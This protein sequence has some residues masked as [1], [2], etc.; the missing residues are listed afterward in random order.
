MLDITYGMYSMVHYVHLWLF[1]GSVVL[2]Q[3][4]A[5]TI[6]AISRRIER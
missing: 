1:G 4:C 6:I 3:A 5:R 2:V